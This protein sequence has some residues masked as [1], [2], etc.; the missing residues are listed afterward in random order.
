[1]KKLLVLILAIFS[2][3]ISS[4]IRSAV[5]PDALMFNA[6]KKAKLIHSFAVVV[7]TSYDGT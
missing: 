7:L 5:I 2:A 6:F 1:M 3:A 4:R